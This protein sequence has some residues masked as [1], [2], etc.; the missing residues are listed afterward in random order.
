MRIFHPASPAFHALAF[1]LLLSIVSIAQDKRDHDN[2][3]T[4]ELYP[5]SQTL[6]AETI[7][8][9]GWGGGDPFD[10]GGDPFGGAGDP[11]ENAAKPYDPLDDLAAMAEL[12]EGSGLKFSPHFS[13][14]M[15]RTSA[16]GHQR[17]KTM[18]QQVDVPAPRIT[19]DFSFIEIPTN[20]V[21]TSKV[22][23]Q[24]GSL[25]DEEVLRLFRDGKARL[26]SLS[27]AS[28]LSGV[29]AQV[30]GV[31]EIIF[32]SEFQPK[33]AVKGVGAVP[34][35]PAA[36]TPASF[37][38]REVGHILN[39]TPTVSAGDPT[40]IYLAL[41]PESA[42][43]TGWLDVAAKGNDKIKDERAGMTPHP[44]FR[45][46]NY[47]GSLRVTDGETVVAFGTPDPDTGNPIYALVTVRLSKSK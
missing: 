34:P 37:E 14:I 38:T 31:K 24:S 44:V 17:F 18:L 15:L 22:F 8:P 16:D 25:D 26:L 45:S 3:F 43:L 35:L 41:L 2:V 13:R 20:V 32:P 1:G 46:L 39:V 10:S 40:T 5:V 23:Q 7:S 33:P 47:T 27:K 6:F 19:V 29:N 12:P 9:A 21:T 4:T 42:I 28:T 36:I 11:F 30:E